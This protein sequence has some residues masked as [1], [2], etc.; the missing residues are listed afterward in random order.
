M[1][2]SFYASAEQ[3]INERIVMT[4]GLGMKESAP[5]GLIVTSPNV[6]AGDRDVP[7]PGSQL[8]IVPTHRKTEAR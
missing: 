1:R 8:K 6:K 3:E 4:T 2:N 7:T 5:F